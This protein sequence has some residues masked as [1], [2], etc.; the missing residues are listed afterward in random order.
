MAS[1]K[2]HHPPSMHACQLPVTQAQWAPQGEKAYHA[3]E[4]RVEIDFASEQL[5]G[6]AAARIH[7]NAI[8]DFSLQ[9]RPTT[10]ALLQ[11]NLAEL[12]GFRLF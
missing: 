1:L 9:S 7:V 2:I 5:G 10:T 4:I 8:G 3:C 11:L 6:A 12:C